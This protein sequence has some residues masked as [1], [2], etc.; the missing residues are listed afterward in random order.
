MDGLPFGNQSHGWNIHEN[1][2]LTSLVSQFFETSF[3]HPPRDFEE[4]CS[5]LGEWRPA[6]CPA[7]FLRACCS[8]RPADAEP[9]APSG[10]AELGEHPGIFSKWDKNG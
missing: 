8:A 6:I 10:G 2:P 9:A 5:P 3:G 1:P 4:T 7:R